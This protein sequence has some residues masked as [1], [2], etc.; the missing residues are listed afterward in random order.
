MPTTIN[1]IGTHYYGKRDVARRPGTCQHCGAEGNLES[2][3]TRLFFVVIFIPI[4]PLKRVR[5]LDSCPR[6]SRHWIVDPEKYEMSRQL[7]VSGAL[8]KYRD[9]PS[10][11]SALVAH[12]QLMSFHMHQEADKFR[13]TVLEQFP[14]SAEI[15]SGLASHLEQMGRW[16]EATS[17]YEKAFEQKPELPEVRHSLAWRCVN[18]NELDEAYDLLDF[19]R[20]PGAGQSF[21]LAP[22][23]ALAEAYQKRKNHEKT[24]EICEHLLK[25]IP[26]AGDQLVF[27]KLVTQSER[28]LQRQTSIL[29]AKAFSVSGLFDSKRG[30]HAPW[31]R[32]TAFGCVAAALFAMGMAA[33]NEYR[34][35]HRTLHVVNAF[36]QPVEVSIDGRPSVTVSF[37]AAINLSE[38]KHQINI[39]GPVTKQDEITLS[40]SYWQRWTYSPI[41]IFNVAKAAHVS[42][43]NVIYAV[44]PQAPTVRTLSESEF[45]FVPHVDYAFEPPPQSMK[46]DRNTETITKVHVGIDVLQPSGVFAGLQRNNP[47]IALTYAEGYLNRN[48]NDTSLLLLYGD[49]AELSPEDEPRIAEF[50]KAGL[51]RDPLSVVWHRTYTNLKTVAANEAKVAEEYDEQ[52]KKSPENAALLYLRGRVSASRSDQIKYYRLAYE[53]N[54]QLGWPG[55]ALAADAA[56]RGEW[57]EAKE[58][59]DQSYNVLRTDPSLRSLRHYVQLANGEAAGLEP[60]YRQLMQGQDYVDVISSVFYLADTLASQQK[61]DEARNEIRQWLTRVAGPN[62]K[63]ETLASFDEMLDYF[64]GS[65]DGV[66]RRSRF[67]SENRR[68]RAG[69]SRAVES[70]R[71]Q[72]GL[73]FS[74][75][76]NGS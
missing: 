37:R 44:V 70:G 15:R 64:C 4:I 10:E 76:S 73:F 45:S 13:E 43:S 17:L 35:T 31:V 62:A 50:L 26:T 1:G 3:T 58:F 9:E 2:Y 11:E 38:G 51:W 24:L 46:L 39:T 61:Y 54:P 32:W 20:K 75:K 48:P 6:C 36:A 41:W 66:R 47:G 23:Q 19:L 16:N 30:T 7:A 53:K 69:S 5:I 40:T 42:E 52:L 74:G 12:A 55:Y 8:E 56:N 25:E 63:S 67:C 33:L 65:L 68:K 22:L 72:P 34:R 57:R 71:P 27:R 21:N 14:D 28:A 60:E 18:K 59:C 49:H 29:P